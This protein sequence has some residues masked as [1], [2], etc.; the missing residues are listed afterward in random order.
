MDLLTGYG[1]D[2]SDNE[3]N[4]VPTSNSVPVTEG[5]QSTVAQAQQ[6]QQQIQS[7][8]EGVKANGGGIP[9]E[10]GTGDGLWE[11]LPRPAV[12]SSTPSISGLASLPPPSGGE[13]RGGGGGTRKVVTM[14]LPFR[15]ELLAAAL[16]S[17][18]EDEPAAKRVKT[19]GG[20][21]RLMDFLPPPKYDTGIARP[22]GAVSTKAAAPAPPAAAPPPV[23]APGAFGST[24]AGS[25]AGALPADFFTGGAPPAPYGNEAY[26]VR[27]DDADDM[28]GA[29]NHP[30]PAYYGAAGFAASPA[31]YAYT[32]HD[33]GPSASGPPLS[34][35]TASGRVSTAAMPPPPPAG[36]E[37]LIAEALRAEQERASKRGGGG[38]GGMK[39]VEINAKDLTRMDP[40][41][42]EAANSARDALGP[43]YAL[44]LR[45]S[46]APFEGSK[47]ARRKHQIGTLLFNAR[48]QE[49]EHMEKRT[50]G[51]KSKA[52]TAAKY[53]W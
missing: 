23:P 45:R 43:E 6:Q 11:R 31:Y 12:T 32:P 10:G 3:D 20:K 40:A 19:A 44:S 18:D 24:A 47:M 37:D 22:L 34:G 8:R 4:V 21:S 29:A 51:Q 7:E 39:L 42:K 25:S 13:P 17:D 49:L 26:R 1:S 52:E 36:P 9:S 50:Q 27:D 38:A 30:G 5:R 16:D 14:Q 28:P 53:G 48:M 46:A 41:A 35:G 33:Y 2:A 15:K